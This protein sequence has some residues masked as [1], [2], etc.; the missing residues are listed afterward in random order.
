MPPSP[1]KTAANFGAMSALSCFAM[2][3]ILYYLGVNPLGPA[4][5]LAVWVPPL[6]IVLATKRFRDFESGGFISYSTAFRIGF[7][8][9]TCG[10]LLYALIVYI[11]G[12]LIDPALID[13]FKEMM[14]ADLEETESLMRSVV[15]D[16]VYEQSIEEMKNTTLKTIAMTDFFYKCVGGLII[17][18]IT[19]AVLKRNH[20]ETI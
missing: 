20:P 2:F 4:S 10:G 3:L 19:A 17:S 13:N 12:T 11:F 9:A 16:S 18:L 7:L 8:T 5:W 14:L 6:F 15:G 1:F